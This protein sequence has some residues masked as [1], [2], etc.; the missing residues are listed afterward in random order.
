M[1]GQTA[2][3]KQILQQVKILQFKH[4][5]VSVSRYKT[6]PTPPSLKWLHL[7]RYIYIFIVMNAHLL[8]C[9]HRSN[10]IKESGSTNFWMA[11]LFH[12]HSK[13]KPS[14]L[15]KKKKKVFNLTYPFTSDHPGNQTRNKLRPKSSQFL[16][17]LQLPPQKKKVVKKQQ[18]Q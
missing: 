8:C 1:R 9:C 10:N 14:L 16:R 13:H 11:S 6:N 7:G 17:R 4:T 15:P 3:L 5:L 18:F 2:I 12:Y